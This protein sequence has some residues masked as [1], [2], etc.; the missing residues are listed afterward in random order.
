MVN[1]CVEN[2]FVMLLLMRI[3]RECFFTVGIVF[4]S[5]YLKGSCARSK[6]DVSPIV[7]NGTA[8]V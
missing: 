7:C 3:K 5:M 4:S 6:F 1:C 8:T 2:A